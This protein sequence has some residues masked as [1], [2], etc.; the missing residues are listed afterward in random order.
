MAGLRFD[1]VNIV[2]A[3]VVGLMSPADPAAR[4]AWPQLSE[5]T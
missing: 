5:F 4:S 3:D 1:Q 2:I